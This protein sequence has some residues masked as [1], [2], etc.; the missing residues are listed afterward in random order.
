MADRYWVGGSG[1]WNASSTANWSTSSGGS[2]GAS[3][4]TSA[5]NVI[6]DANS[7]VGTGAFTVTV[8]GTSAAPAV[9]NDFSTGGAGGALD[10][11]MTL[12]MG[13]TA[14]LDCYGSLTLPATNLT[15]SPTS[16]AALNFKA[17]TTGKTLTTNGVSLVATT[18]AFDGVGGAWTLGSALTT[19]STIT[20]TNGTFSTSASNYAL[21]ITALLSSNSNTRTITLNASTVTLSLS[22]TCVNFGTSTN[23]TFNA[24]TSTITCSGASPTFTGGGLTYYNVTFSSAASGTTTITGVNTFNNLT[25]TSRSATGYRIINFGADQT[26]SGTLTLGAANT[27]IRRIRVSSDVFTTRRTITLN[28]TLATLADVDFRD[29]GVAGTVATP[30][31]GT[32]LGDALNNNNITFDAPKTVYWNLAGTQNWSATGWAT[33]N[34]GTPAVNN[35]PLVQDTATF[36]EAGSAG[37]ITIDQAWQIGTIQMADGVSNRTTA[38]TLA[39]GTQTPSLYGNVTLFSNL[40]L[41]GTGALNF[42]KQGATAVITSAGISFTQPLILNAPSGTFQ[43]AD[44]LTNTGTAFTLGA[45]TLDLSSGNRT[46]TCVTFASSNSNTRSISFGTGNITVTGNAATIFTTATATGFTVT[47]TPVVNATYSGSTGTRGISFGNAGEANAISVNVTAGTDQVNLVTT[48]GSFKNIDFTGFSGTMAFSNSINIFGNFTLSTGM[49]VSSGTQTPSFAATS[50]TQ[51]ITTNGKTIDYNL[52]VNAP[53]ATVQL[54]DNLT[55]GSTKTLTLA[56]GTL[57]LSSGNRTLSTGIFS[58]SN[59][60]TRAILFGT[61]QITVTGNN[62][63]V[64]D[65]ATSTGFTY[66]GTSKIEFTYAGAVGTRNI[67]GGEPGTGGTE[68][69]SLNYLIS[70]GSDIVAMGTNARRYRDINLTG[71]SGTFSNLQRTLYG[72]LTISSGTTVGAGVEVTTFAATSG[73]QNITSNGKTLDF[74]IIV[75]APGATV[76]LQDA[77]ALGSTRT[78]TLTAGTLNANNQNCTTGLFASSN[79]NVRTLTMGSGTWTIQGAGTAWDAS[80]STNLTVNG[81]TSTIT[82]TSASAKTFAGGDKAYYILN[83]GGAGALTITGSNTFTTLSTAVLPTTITF[84]AGTTQSVGNFNLSGTSGNLVTINST[85]SGSQFNLYKISGSKALVSYM[86]ITDSAAT[87]SNIWFSPTSQGNVNGGNNTGWNFNR[88]GPA[89]PNGFLLF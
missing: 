72:S 77:L 7:N 70:A 87:P 4:P 66:T 49:T 88:S 5:D 33:T 43:L 57:D 34:N 41:T 16:G 76:Q 75:N 25:Q 47:G 64:F 55:I 9:C 38:F 62:A 40:I 82:M 89:L 13:A 80:T 54:Q 46:L 73:T 17:T 36:T 31:T 61:G 32:R 26:V 22:G 53:G 18:V 69:N 3:A 68:S 52:S 8:T 81:G 58:S 29:I 51:Q 63:T 27:A 24:N 19:T 71:F 11:V 79:T 45:G 84:T 39:T 78:L 48:G 15:W 65:V 20:V 2:A 42:L 50:G 56:V 44:N 35:F 74:P 67:R 86:L 60:N 83:Q 21:T 1:N 10:G 28:G 59:S 12:S 30:W 23:L 6:F 14:Q 37:T 85:S